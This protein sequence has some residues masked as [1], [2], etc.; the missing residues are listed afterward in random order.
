MIPIFF[1]H[2]KK[3]GHVLDIKEDEIGIKVIFS[4][5]Q[6]IEDNGF[7]SIAYKTI[8]SSKIENTRI[9]SKLELFEI[10]VVSSPAQRKCT[11][12]K[13]VTRY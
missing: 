10:S 6:E 8:E 9:I 2:K 13:L 4:V 7:L 12:E 5:W 11:Y 3:I 1:E